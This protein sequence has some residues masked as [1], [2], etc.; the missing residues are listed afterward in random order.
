MRYD[1]ILIHLWDIWHAF[2]AMSY[3]LFYDVFY[4]LMFLLLL[5]AYLMMQLMWIW[6]DAVYVMWIYFMMY[7]SMCDND[8]KLT[9][10]NASKCNYYA[11][12]K[13]AKMT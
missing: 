13:C 12:C 6:Y 7:E 10:W 8:L 9:K 2:L 5:H 3:A 4:D 11:I 1:V